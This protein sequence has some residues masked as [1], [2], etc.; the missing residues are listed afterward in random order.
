MNDTI[1]NILGCIIAFVFCVWLTAD[2]I[3]KSHLANYYK[4]DAVLD[5]IE[6]SYCEGFISAGG[7]EEKAERQALAYKNIMFM[8]S[9]KASAM[10]ADKK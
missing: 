8:A 3:L 5:F 4:E 7:E 10:Y 1:I 2:V 9:K 6:M